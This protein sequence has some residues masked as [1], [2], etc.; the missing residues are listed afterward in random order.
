MKAINVLTI[1][2][3]YCLIGCS[4]ERTEHKNT[5][6]PRDEDL[7]Q[8]ETIDGLA[9]FVVGST[10]FQSFSKRYRQYNWHVSYSELFYDE[11]WDSPWD[12]EW[13]KAYK[14]FNYDN[15]VKLI[16]NL[17]KNK[18]IRSIKLSNYKV[19]EIEL[20]NFYLAFFKDTLVALRFEPDKEHRMSLRDHYLSKYG[21]GKGF[22]DTL[23]LLDVIG[24]YSIKEERE[25]S[26]QLLTTSYSRMR[27][28]DKKKGYDMDENIYFYWH[29]RLYPMYV[30]A[31]EDEVNKYQ[32]SKSESIK[33]S[34]TAF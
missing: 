20:Q 11:E 23:D 12:V 26:N 28:F 33:T 18:S 22:S 2:L 17:K 27:Y 14:D 19:G 30:N 8:I 7:E 13:E 34:L 4:G 1:L 32:E 21:C 6:E 15:R 24:R 29:K 3:L 31:I 16:D 5:F 9:D 25:W 10:T